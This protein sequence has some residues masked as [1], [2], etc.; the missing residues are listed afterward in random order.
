M[1]FQA[2]KNVFPGKQK[3]ICKQKKMKFQVNKNEVAGIQ[4][5]SSKQTKINL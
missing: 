2:N 4:N 1:K 5:W 3:L